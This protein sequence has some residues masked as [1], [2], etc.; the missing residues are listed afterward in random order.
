MVRRHEAK[1][2]RTKKRNMQ[3]HYLNWKIQFTSICNGLGRYKINKNRVDLSNTI[4][5]LDL[6]DTYRVI[7]SLVTEYTFFPLKVA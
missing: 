6:L 5:Q 4:N 3:T 7:H 1:I 2:D